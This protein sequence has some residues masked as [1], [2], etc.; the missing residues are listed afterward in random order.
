MDGVN[1]HL[2]ALKNVQDYLRE[3]YNQVQEWSNNGKLDGFTVKLI[4]LRDKQ[5]KESWNF[6]LLP[7]AG[8][9]SSEIRTL[10]SKIIEESEASPRADGRLSYDIVFTL[11]DDVQLSGNWEK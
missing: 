5:V 8:D 4:S 7:G 9:I 10:K 3:I 2:A 11:K 6:K 1:Y